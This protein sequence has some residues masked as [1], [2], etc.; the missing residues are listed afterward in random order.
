MKSSKFVRVFLCFVCLIV[1]MAESKSSIAAKNDLGTD[2]TEGYCTKLVKEN[3]PVG[4]FSAEPVLPESPLNITQEYNTSKKEGYYA[5]GNLQYGHDGIDVH[6]ASRIIGKNEIKSFQ[7]GIVITSKNMGQKTSWGESIIIATR[8]N[9]FSEQILTFHYHHMHNS[10]QKSGGYLTSR[11]KGVCDIVQRGD[12][13]GK[14]GSTGKSTGSHLH[15]GVRRWQN[16]DELVKAIDAGG[17]SLFG[18]GYVYGDKNKLSKNLDPIGLLYNSFRDFEAQSLSDP[19]FAWAQPYVINIRKKGIEFG[20][21]D[22]K[23]GA[24]EYVKRREIARWLKTGRMLL[25]QNKSKPTFPDDVPEMDS[26]YTYIQMLTTWPDN[27]IPVI[28]PDHTCYAFTKR[29][30]PEHNVNRAEALKMVILTYY[31]QDFAS[32]YDNMIWRVEKAYGMA[33]LN[34]FN[35]VN[36]LYWYAPYVYYGESIGLVEKQKLFRPGDPITRAEI[37]KWVMEGHWRLIGEKKN[38]CDSVTCMA[39]AYCENSTHQC[40]QFPLCMP[41]ETQQCA[42]G[43]GYD[44]CENGSCNQA[45][46]VPTDN[47]DAGTKPDTSTEPD[48]ANNA[49]VEIIPDPQPT[50]DT[51]STPELPIVVPEAENSSETPPTAIDAES[52]PVQDIIPDTEKTPEVPTCRCSTGACCNGCNYY[53]SSYSCEQKYTY[54]CEGANPGQNSQRAIIR[55]Y[56]S[57]NSSDCNGRTEQFGWQTLE[58][59]SS[60]QKCQM[61]GST[62]VCVGSC[63]DRLIADRSSSCYGNPQTAGT[64]TLCLEITQVKDTN[65]RYRICKKSA[66]FGNQFTY[67]LRDA[68]QSVNFTEYTESPGQTCTQWKE[69][70][71]GYIKSYGALNGA[72]LYAEV[73]SPK[74]C[75]QSSCKYKTGSVT[76]R[77]ECR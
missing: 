15:F 8:T 18:N 46:P 65:F 34:K 74:G 30:C 51:Q 3:I 47:L 55:H 38:P 17:K 63:Q 53:D 66:T 44:P 33:L 73:V 58:D 67:R 11:R 25:S 36:P 64:P 45:D 22:G 7:S 12:I 75:T 62:P 49:D 19:A 32:V 60:I 68:N 52:A 71:V 4:D 14:E 1:M 20:N 27:K 39:G 69:F 16:I 9:L 76:I 48:N 70:G 54:R 56:C 26:D 72:G 6:G 37:A 35:D 10:L 2:I 24:T 40:R 42:V 57:G 41:S 23:Y 5:D 43:G 21:Y 59:C 31:H 28:N 29:F 13:I 77:K 61:T 50:P